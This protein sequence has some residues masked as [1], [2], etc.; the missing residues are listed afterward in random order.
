MHCAP[1]HLRAVQGFP[2]TLPHTTITAPASATQPCTVPLCPQG[3][4]VQKQIPNPK[5][6]Q[7]EA[8]LNNVAPIKALAFELWTIDSGYTFDNVL[9]S[10]DEAEAQQAREELWKPKHAAEVS[11][12]VGLGCMAWAGRTQRCVS[13]SLGSRVSSHQPPPHNCPTLHSTVP[14]KDH[15][16]LHRDCAHWCMA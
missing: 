4:W 15:P 11:A 16:A 1:A 5:Y 3:E 10:T 2:S 14:S 7:D 8:P 12:R 9:L 6:Y 13:S